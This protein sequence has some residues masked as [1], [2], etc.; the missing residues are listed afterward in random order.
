VPLRPSPSTRCTR[1]SAPVRGSASHLR[2]TVPWQHRYRAVPRSCRPIGPFKRLQ[3]G[4][5]PPP[6]QAPVLPAPLLPPLPRHRS[7]TAPPK[8]QITCLQGSCPTTAPAWSPGCTHTI[9]A[10]TAA[11]P[12]PLLRLKKRK[13]A[14]RTWGQVLAAWRMRTS[15]GWRFACRMIGSPVRRSAMPRCT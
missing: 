3:E 1:C 5:P 4:P 10:A 15:Q 9:A 8:P 14:A 2:G 6:P 13:T 7:A 12:P 11:R